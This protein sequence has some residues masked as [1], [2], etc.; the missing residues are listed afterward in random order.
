M[1]EVEI[2]RRGKVQ[3]RVAEELEPLVGGGF[4]VTAHLQERPVRKRLEKETAVPD[5]VTE[6]VF[7]PAVVDPGIG[8][9]CAGNSS[10]NYPGIPDPPQ[11]TAQYCHKCPELIFLVCSEE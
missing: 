4:L 6:D 9:I 10:R 1:V 5:G 8:S 7:E 11:E 2:L 3:D